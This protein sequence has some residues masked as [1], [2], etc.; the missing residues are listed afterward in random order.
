M[1]KIYNT[2]FKMTYYH[3]IIVEYL[4]FGECNNSLYINADLG[5]TP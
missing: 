2:K 3:V 5:Q 4:T 1:F